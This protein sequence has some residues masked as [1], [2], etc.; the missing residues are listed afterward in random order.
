LIVDKEDSPYV[1]D[2]IETCFKAGKKVL[3]LRKYGVER[4]EKLEEFIKLMQEHV[5]ISDFRTCVE[6]EEKIQKGILFELARKYR[7]T[8]R[9]IEGRVESFR[10]AF[11]LIN[12]TLN[13]LFLVTRTLP[14]ITPPKENDYFDKKIM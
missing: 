3:M 13:D 7:E 8:P 11:E 5:F 6:L 12:R 14:I 1:R 9:I 2:E 4:E 10:Y